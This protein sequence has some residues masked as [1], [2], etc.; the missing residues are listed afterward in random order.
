MPGSIRKAFPAART[1]SPALISSKAAAAGAGF[2][3]VAAKRLSKIAAG[4]ANGG[5]E[6]EERAGGE[7]D[8]QGPGGDAPIRRDVELVRTERGEGRQR[9]AHTSLGESEAADAAEQ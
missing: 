9:R 1:R 7:R 4:H 2:E 8:Q 6:T 3:G 5:G